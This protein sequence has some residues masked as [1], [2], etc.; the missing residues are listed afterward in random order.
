M[1]TAI[2]RNRLRLNFYHFLIIP[3]FFLLPFTLYPIR[4]C[5]KIVSYNVVLLDFLLTI[6]KFIYIIK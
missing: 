5:G 3:L 2:L 1:S 4:N 6:R